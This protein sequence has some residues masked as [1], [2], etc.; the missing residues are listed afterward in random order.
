MG[1]ERREEGEEE[2]R[3]LGYLLKLA[4]QRETGCLPAHRHLHSL[5]SS[6]LSAAAIRKFGEI[7]HYSYIWGNVPFPMSTG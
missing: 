6:H 4:L 1:M 5:S 3:I 7:E 2:G